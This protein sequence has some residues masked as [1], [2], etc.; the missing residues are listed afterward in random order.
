MNKKRPGFLTAYGTIAAILTIL[1]VVGFGLVAQGLLFSPGPLNANAGPALGGVTS[2]AGL[3]NQCSSCHAPF[4]DPAGM[5]GR[6]VACHMDIPAQLDDPSKLHGNLQKNNPNMMACRNCHPDHLGPNAALT[7]LSKADVSHAAFGYALTAHQLKS[8]G[9]SFACAD[10]HTVSYVKF[11]QGV[12]A[13]CHGQ[14]KADFMQAHI[15]AYGTGCLACHDG[16]DTYGHTFNHALVAFQLT[17]KHAQA[18]CAQCHTGARTIADLKATSQDCNS[19]HAKDDAHQGQLGTNCASCHTTAGW[20]P[21]AFDHNLASFKL[22][23]SH[24]SVPCTSCHVNAVFKGTPTDCYSCHKKDDKHNE[25]FGTA[26]DACHTPNGWLPATFDHSVFPLTGGHA[27]L[28]CTRCHTTGVFT[29]LSTACAACHANPPFHAGLFTGTPC[30]ACH[31]TSS[32][33]PAKYT[34]PHPGGC[35]G[36]C[37]DHGGASCRD[38][39]TVTLMTATCTKCHDSNNPGGG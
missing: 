11:D 17:G 25:Q 24:A 20:L 7:N 14:I 18:T 26:C 15:Q 29:G 32:W 23:G 27:G 28:P 34:G 16:V 39:H 30:S 19:C 36:N 37:I 21:A 22:I 5:A 31:N 2:H 8:D 1:I 13:T 6:C 38:C 9:S 33:T 12:C 10:C 4:W 3:S 35:D